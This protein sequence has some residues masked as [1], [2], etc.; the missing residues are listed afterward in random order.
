MPFAIPKGRSSISRLSFGVFNSIVTG[1]A[2]TSWWVALSYHGDRHHPLARLTFDFFPNLEVM[3]TPWQRVEVF[4]ILTQMERG[5][6]LDGGGARRGQRRLE[7]EVRL[8]YWPHHEFSWT[9]AIRKAVT[10]GNRFGPCM[11]IRSM[12]LFHVAIASVLKADR[13]LTFDDEQR[14][15]AKACSLKVLDLAKSARAKSSSA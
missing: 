5:G 2:D 8:G 3:W 15:P 1:Y 7:Q 6:L 13:F 11:P 10:L 4:N 9:N 14:A 12:D